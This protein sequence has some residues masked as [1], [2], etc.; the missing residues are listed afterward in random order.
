MVLL[1]ISRKRTAYQKKKKKKKL[2]KEQKKHMKQKDLPLHL[3]QSIDIG[4]QNYYN[5]WWKLRCW[6]LCN[7]WPCL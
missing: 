5:H 2:G 7:V 1:C 3:F 4:S 6:K